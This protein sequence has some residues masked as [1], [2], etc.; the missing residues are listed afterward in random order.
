MVNRAHPPGKMVW[1]LV[2]RRHRDTKPQ[3]LRH[4]GHRWHHAHRLI[5]GPLRSTANRWLEVLGTA[6]DIVAA[7]DVGDEH[8]L[9]VPFLEELS[10]GRPVGQGVEVGGAVLGVSP[11][12]WGLVARACEL[13]V[14]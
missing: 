2:T 11:E 1:L 13:S 8:A 4:C 10:E 9:E 5:H 7:Q 14:S 12:A 6:V 3:A